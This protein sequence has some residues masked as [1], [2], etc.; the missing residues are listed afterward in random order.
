MISSISI[1]T[2]E[3]LT[4]YA[5]ADGPIDYRVIKSELSSIPNAP[6]FVVLPDDKP[7]ASCLITSSVKEVIEYLEIWYN[8]PNNPSVS[9]QVFENECYADVFKYLG[10]LYGVYLKEAGE[11]SGEMFK[12]AN[13]N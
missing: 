7:D 1:H 13:Q 5:D 12:V 3:D 4:E 2:E 9:I 6:I 10:D 8:A 11:E